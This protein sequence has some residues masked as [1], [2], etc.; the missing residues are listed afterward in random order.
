MS[1]DDSD[2]DP[3]YS[4][5]T[6]YALT[7]SMKD[8]IKDAIG[9]KC[10]K[11]EYKFEK[12][13]LNIHHIYPVKDADGSF[14]L[15]SPN[16]LIV[17]CS[18]CHRKADR[19]KIHPVEMVDIVSNR[20][21]N[22]KSSLNDTLSNRN[23]VISTTKSP[24]A[25]YTGDTS[26]GNSIKD[27]SYSSSY[28]GFGILDFLLTGDTPIILF[29]SAILTI[30][31]YVFLSNWLMT[32]VKNWFINIINPNGLSATITEAILLLILILSF[33]FV[34]VIIAF[35]ISALIKKLGYRKY[36]DFI[37]NNSSLYNFIIKSNNF[38]ITLSIIIFILIAIIPSGIISYQVYAGEGGLLRNFLI[39]TTYSLL[40][41][42]INALT[43]IVTIIIL[44]S[45]SVFLT[46][47]GIESGK[48]NRY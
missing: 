8:K 7:N 10:E 18:N 28:Y 6:R 44:F 11:C 4:R 29:I 5:D 31:L 39:N 22:V 34:S 46:I 21:Y 3:D 42:T 27:Y 45:A 15:N 48:R 38:A 17:L 1:Y 9:N 36:L 32:G 37:Y 33:I 2:Y 26:G 14:D 35:S 41:F 30:M 43:F 20:E 24:P 25:T 47:F 19:G 12:F 16:N 13:E 23:L 40:D